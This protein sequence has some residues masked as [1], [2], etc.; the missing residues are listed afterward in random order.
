MTAPA[1]DPQSRTAR[2][3]EGLR[4]RILRHE[5]RMGDPLR[6]EEVASWFEA[7]RVPARDALKRLETEGLVE[8]VGRKYAIRSYSYDEILVTYRIRAALEHLSVELAVRLGTEAQFMHI[9]AQLDRQ[10]RAVTSMGRADFS[11]LD[12]EFHMMIAELTGNAMLIGETETVLNR[13]RLIRSNELEIDNG[14]GAALAD[15]LRIFDALCRRDAQ[16]AK[17]ELNYHYAT[18]VRLHER[19][20]V[21]LNGDLT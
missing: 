16:T 8:R 2:V 19:G 6:E 14:P 11:A 18:T 20:G 3:Y 12:F 15:H 21:A 13:V 7:S 1:A 10:R 17:S 9:A 5:F 4:A